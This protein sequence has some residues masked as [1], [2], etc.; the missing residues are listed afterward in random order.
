MNEA[1]LCECGCGGKAPIAKK[2][3]TRAGHIK[4]QP[5]RFISGHH[6]KIQPKGNKAKNWRGGTRRMEEGRIRIYKPEH[7]RSDKKGYVLRSILVVEEKSSISIPAG[8]IIHHANEDWTDD[9]PSNLVVCNNIAYHMYLHQRKRAYDACGNANWRKC[10]VCKEYDDKKNLLKSGT[11]HHHF[12]C[13]KQY[14]KDLAK[15][16]KDIELNNLTS[17]SHTGGQTI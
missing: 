12:L 15:S 6:S 11:G 7:P 16:H 9:S 8:C 14:L 17:I 4:G 2:T 1:G 3:S 13:R 10:W 5:T